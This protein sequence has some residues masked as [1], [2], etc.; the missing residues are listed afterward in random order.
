MVAQHTM[1]SEP[2][3]VLELRSVRGTGGGPEK[4]ILLGAA[5]ADPGKVKVTV[6]YIRDV[7]DDVF[8]IDERAKAAGVDY[9]EITERHSTDPAIWSPLRRLTAERRIDV[10][11][12]H[13]Y[14]TDL[15]AWAL[16][17]RAPVAL[18]AT[19]HGWTGHSSRERLVYY[20]ADKRLLARYPLVL[21]VSGQVRSELLRHG[22][23]ASRVKVLLN[24]IDHR[25]FRRDPAR[26]AAARTAYDARPGELLIG[27]VGRLEPQKRFDALIEAVHRV[28]V[29]FPRLRLLIAGEG[30]EREALLNTI[31]AHGA[32]R[33]CQLLGQVDDVAFLHHALDLFVQ[34]SV[35]EGT[36]NVVL[37]AMALETPLVATDAG[38]TTELVRKGI[39]GLIVP[40][41]DARALERGIREALVD[42]EARRAR[43]AAARR[44][45]ESDLSFVQRVRTLDD[46]YV[47]LATARAR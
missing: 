15:L 47:S 44:R 2:V 4:T 9:T 12:A 11:H 27:A 1:T 13:D 38:G 46:I 10:V 37:E 5:M 7:R 23:E 43:A 26:V 8:R 20:P 3:H 30:S 39:D 16:A 21:A 33:W 31:H 36:P 19:A 29:D 45:V 25:A 17:L 6:C 32:G 22:A 34:S 28:R 18:M 40:K 42:F 35:Y 14:K 41:A 24:G